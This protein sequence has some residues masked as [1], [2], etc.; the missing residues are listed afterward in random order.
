MDANDKLQGKVGRLRLVGDSQWSF[1]GGLFGKGYKVLVKHRWR[2]RLQTLH[3]HAHQISSLAIQLG[4]D[5]AEL[6]RREIV[7][8]NSG[9]EYA[10]V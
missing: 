7:M 6:A 3:K 9:F 8:K 10:P 2:P 5:P 1:A 4:A